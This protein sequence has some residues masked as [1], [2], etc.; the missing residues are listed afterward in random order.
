MNNLNVIKIQIIFCFCFFLL[1]C[2]SLSFSFIDLRKNKTVLD[3]L[4]ENKQK[5]VEQK[6]IHVLCKKYNLEYFETSAMTGRGVKTCLL[7][8]VSILIDYLL[9]RLCP[10]TYEIRLIDLCD[11]LITLDDLKHLTFCVDIRLL[12]AMKTNTKNRLMIV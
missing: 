7:A 11:N 12:Y 2:I 1:I 8:A 6:D 4:K 5:P 10:F 9:V 3:R